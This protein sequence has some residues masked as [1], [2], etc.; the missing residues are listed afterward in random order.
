[1]HISLS[2]LLT[3][4]IQDGDLSSASVLMPASCPSSPN[5]RALLPP[6]SPTHLCLDYLFCLT[7]Q[8]RPQR[9]EAWCSW[10][11]SLHPDTPFT[12]VPTTL[13]AC[14]ST[15]SSSCSLSCKPHLPLRT[16]RQTDRRQDNSRPVKVEVKGLMK[17]QQ[18]AC[19]HQKEKTGVSEPRSWEAF[20]VWL[21]CFVCLFCLFLRYW[22]LELRAYTLSH[23][24]SPF[25]QQVFSR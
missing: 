21:V 14:V 6:C 25:L 1:M 11:S 17:G 19:E 7:N 16:D 23:S 2:W 9:P 3:S 22:G 8:E 15:S 18:L 24:T 20:F 5:S 12:T 10:P 4:F 13:S